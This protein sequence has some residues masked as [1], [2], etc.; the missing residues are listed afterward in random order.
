M[1]MSIENGKQKTGMWYIKKKY[2]INTTNKDKAIVSYLYNLP[3]AL[4]WF[5]W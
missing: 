5:W 4:K 3:A 1:F 2:F